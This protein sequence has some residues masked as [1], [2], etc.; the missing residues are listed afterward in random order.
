MFET[1][2]MELVRRGI[3]MDAAW[4]IALAIFTE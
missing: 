4:T 1:F 2:W 3:P